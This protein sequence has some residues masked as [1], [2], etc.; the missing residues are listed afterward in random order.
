MENT[1]PVSLRQLIKNRQFVALWLSQLVSNFGDWLAILALFSL[2]AFKMKSTSYEVA[3]IMISF[4]I[5][6]A[7]LGPVAGVFVDRWDVKKTMITSDL[8]RAVI[9]ALLVLPT[10]GLYQ[11]Y[12]LVFALSAVSCFFL[13]AQSVAIPLIVRK[14]ELLL[15]NSI[16]AQTIQFNRIISPAVS[17]LLVAWAGEKLCF[18]VDSFSFLFSAAVLTGLALRRDQRD[19]DKDARS[20]VKELARGL[21]F[22]A[23]HRAI[24]FVIVSLVA[25]ILAVGAFDALI[26]VFIRDILSSDEQL[27]GALVSLVG[28]GTILG[29]LVIAKTG[30]RYSK[31]SLVELGI[32]AMGL[33]VLIMAALSKVAVVVACSLL[34]GVGVAYVL[35]PSQTLIQEETPQ[36]ML[37]R[38]TSTSMSLMTV[39]QLVS[40]LVAGAVA[41]LIGIRNLY[42]VVAAMLLVTAMFGY[43]YA[44]V[45]RVGATKAEPTLA[46]AADQD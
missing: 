14:E 19:Y 27:F 17:G 6:M 36:E 11:I 9:A 29:S 37:G 40:F 10:T 15:A 24:L 20:I 28:V 13:P 16:N 42:Y 43:V 5:P 34:L 46:A 22:I 39:A 31:V 8:A 45:N 26:S 33:S 32:F 38:V 18:Y 25:A 4:I 2:V 21:K 41:G 1:G 7:F 44:R 12:I 30:R 23:N 35:V 3:G